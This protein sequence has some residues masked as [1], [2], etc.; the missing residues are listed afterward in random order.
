GGRYIGTGD[1][2]I[3]RDPDEGWVNLGTYR[4]MVHDETT[5]GFYIS[6]GGHGRIHR[7]KYF[8][9]NQPCKVAISF[10]H[11][12][13]IFVA[14]SLEIPNGMSEYE[15][16]GGV[17]GEPV[18]VIKGE[19]TGLPIPAHAEIVIEG[20]SDPDERRMEG[21]FGEYTGYYGSD[22]RPEPVI[23]IK[24]IMHRGAPVLLAKPPYRPLS[25][26]LCHR[27][28]LRTA[29]IWDEVEKAGVPDVK[30]VWY[31][32][33]GIENLITVVAIRQRYPGHARQAGLIATMCR[34][35][36]NLGRYTIVVDDD[37]DITSVDDVLWAWATRSD[38][39]R[40]IEIVDRCWSNP[41]DPAM[42]KGTGNFNSRA[43]IDACRPFEWKEE[44][45]RVVE[46]SEELKE[47]TRQR[48]SDILS[49]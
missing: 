23:K 41:L 28:F 32:V 12:P 3:T 47:R 2:V 40:S 5:L 33:A 44:F 11:D 6:P 48:W 7:D 38:P 1:V 21:P 24:S 30:G 18:D 36:G 16:I 39:K 15:W 45:S 35:G 43:I 9:R 8:E 37:I 42:Q 14:G 19:Y 25:G 49:D 17:R 31:L 22:A 13:L 26:N 27:Y 46:P 10:G 29:Q 20:E 4:I 34:S